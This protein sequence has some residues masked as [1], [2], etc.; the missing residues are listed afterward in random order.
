[1]TTASFTSTYIADYAE[2]TPVSNR[3]VKSVIDGNGK[4]LVFTHGS[5]DQL[6]AIAQRDGNETGWKQVNLTALL[7]PGGVLTAYDVYQDPASKRIRVCAALKAATGETSLN[8]TA[9]FDPSRIGEPDFPPWR[10]VET[11]A[12]ETIDHILLDAREG[13][14]TTRKGDQ[15][16]RYSRIDEHDQRTDYEFSERADQVQDIRLGRWKG[17]PGLFFLYALGSQQTVAFHGFPN[18]PAFPDRSSKTRFDPGAGRVDGIA[19]VQS[20]GFDDGRPGDHDLYIIGEGGLCSFNSVTGRKDIL[21][22]AKGVSFTNLQFSR[23]EDA[24][25]CWFMAGSSRKFL[26]YMYREPSSG[27]WSVPLALKYDIEQYACVRS[28]GIRNHL[29]YIDNR[30]RLYHF[31]EDEI[32]SVWHDNFV[33]IEGTGTFK[34]SMGYLTEVKFSDPVPLLERT[35]AVITLTSPVNLYISVDYACYQI[36]PDIPVSIP[37]HGRESLHLSHTLNAGFVDAVLCLKASFLNEPLAVDMSKSIYDRIKALVASDLKGM[38]DLKR[39]NG[40]P[41]LPDEYRNKE[42]TRKTI[43][44]ALRFLIEFRD[45][46]RANGICGVALRPLAIYAAPGMNQ[47]TMTLTISGVAAGAL[48]GGAAAACA[49]MGG[50]LLIP[51]DPVSEGVLLAGTLI[52]ALIG[53]IIGGAIGW[54]LELVRTKKPLDDDNKPDKPARQ[55]PGLVFSRIGCVGTMTLYDDKCNA[56]SAALDVSHMFSA[57]NML[58]SFVGITPSDLPDWPTDND[59]CIYHAYLF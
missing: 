53:A 18:N 26:Y 24:L 9:L 12:D 36:G 42:K 50:A 10:R 21:L 6:Y 33:P 4:P 48:A 52:C 59:G 58:L 28:T 40:G 43:A 45:D 32:S 23:H 46:C 54:T 44:D 47:E 30:K 17:Q 35:D 39:S 57:I 27:K 15:N 41:L 2:D 56:M 7:K 49:F 22:P 3:T 38:E 20:G 14:I 51:K 13:F 1:M 25:S 11:P 55:C 19:L 16:A 31:F 37:L 5:D 34:K 8:V 29:F